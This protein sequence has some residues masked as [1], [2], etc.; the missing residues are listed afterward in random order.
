MSGPPTSCSLLTTNSLF[1]VLLQ[2]AAVTPLSYKHLREH[3][4]PVAMV[5]PT[6][7]GRCTGQ[8]TAVPSEKRMKI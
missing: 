7:L 5:T 1:T 8:A 3:D 6:A 2:T 4:P